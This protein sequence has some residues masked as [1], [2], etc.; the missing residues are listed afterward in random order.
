MRGR[1]FVAAM[2]GVPKHAL[3]RLAG[4][5]SRARLPGPMLRAAMRGF[6][7]RYGV[8]LSESPPLDSYRTFGEFFARPLL[9]G[10]RPIAPG[11]EVAVSPVDA[12]VSE[13]GLAVE[14]RLVQAKGS[15]YSTQALLGDAK[16][17]R[18]VAGGAFATL[19]LSPRDYHRIHFPLGGRIT[20][21]RYLPGTLWPVNPTSVEN[22]PGLFARNERLVTAM[23]TPLGACAVVAVGATVVG[24]V[25]AFYDAGV[26]LTNLPGAA[27]RACDYS[28]PIAVEKGA[29]LGAFEMGSTVILLFQAGRVALSSF[30]APGARVQV[31]QAIGGRP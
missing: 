9:P 24:R 22:V 4:A 12:V 14:G 19:Y 10:K 25:R 31:G 26:P 17:A 28:A 18:Q 6:A 3:S 16:L 13:S 23:E 7:A 5:A 8:D 15:H 30:V 21:W 2:R 1:L 20:G 11:D 27:P 29:E